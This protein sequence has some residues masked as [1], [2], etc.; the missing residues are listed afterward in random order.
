LIGRTDLFKIINLDF[1]GNIIVTILYN[2]LEG[3]R[4]RQRQIEKP[5]GRVQGFIGVKTRETALLK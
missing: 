3:Q 5:G 1:G 2:G 4:Q